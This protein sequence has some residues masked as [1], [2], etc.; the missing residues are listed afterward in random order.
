M[1]LSGVPGAPAQLCHSDE[2]SAA[3][4]LHRIIIRDK[5]LKNYNMPSYISL[6]SSSF[7]EASRVVKLTLESIDRSYSS[8]KIRLVNFMQYIETLN[9][10]IFLY[11]KIYVDKF[12]HRSPFLLCF[13]LENL[14]Y[15]KWEIILYVVFSFYNVFIFRKNSKF[16]D[17]HSKFR[18]YYGIRL[19]LFASCDT[20]GLFLA[21]ISYIF[22]KVGNEKY[23]RER[24]K[25]KE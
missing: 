10:P 12:I 3:T 9:V 20:S 19:L 17:Y 6:G 5:L 1:A 21:H 23:R 8:H 24:E 14:N 22:T 13:R 16:C 4:F 7:I 11:K 18:E 15:I 25:M 2:Q